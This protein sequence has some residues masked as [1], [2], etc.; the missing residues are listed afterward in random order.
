MFPFGAHF[1]L[2]WA[3]PR[4]HFDDHFGARVSKWSIYVYFFGA[5]AGASKTGGKKLPKVFKK[6]AFWEAVDMAQV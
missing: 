1:G 5:F 3:S 4:D 2:L 6:G